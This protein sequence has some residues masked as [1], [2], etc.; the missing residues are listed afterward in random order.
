MNLKDMFAKGDR[1][2]DSMLN[3]YPKI[4]DLSIPQPRTEFV[5]LSDE[6]YYSTM[7]AMPKEITAKVDALIKEK[8]VLPVFIRTDQSSAKHYWKDTC[9]YDGSKEL[10]KHLYELCEFNHCADIEGLPFRSIVVREYIPM[11]SKY[12]AFEDMPVNPERRYFIK[13]GEV[14]C[15]HPYWIKT[16]IRKPSVENWEE[17]S[18]EMNKETEEEIKLLTEYSQIVAD[19]IEGSWSID[20]CKAKDGHWLLLDMAT[21]ENSWHP[22]H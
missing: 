9:Y 1:F 10:W 21:G 16:A 3:W 6:E 11:A 20:Y 7:D 4:K 18:D 2:I 5:L 14:V 13:D 12:T 22:E 17:L 19:K 8:F 15:R